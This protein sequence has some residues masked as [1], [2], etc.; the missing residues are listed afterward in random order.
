MENLSLETWILVAGLLLATG[1]L[2]SK[3]S[4]RLDVPALLLFLVVG[5]LAG[6]EGIGGIEFDSAEHARSIG[7]LALVVIL[8]AGGLDT[9]WSS[10]KSVLAPGLALATAGVILTWLSLAAF[11]W[12]VL[13]NYT[14]F[15][16]GTGGIGWPEALLLA[17]IVS[18]T[19]AAAVFSVFRTSPVQPNARL[20]SLLELESGS[21][22]PMAVLITT[23]MLGIMTG[24]EASAEHI[25]L[26]LISQLTLGTLIGL[27]LGFAGAWLVRHVRLS[28]PGLY[29]V[30]VLA[31]GL[32]TFGLADLVNGNGFLA[33]YIA[34]VV[35]GNNMRSSRRLPVMT[36]H[37][38]LSWVCQITMF[39]TLGLLAFPSQLAPVAPVSIV[40]ALFLMFVARPLGVFLCLLPF[41]FKRNEMAYTSWVG[42]RGS[43]PV[44]LATFPTAYGVPGGE[45]IFN[46]VFFI[47]L[48]SMLLQGLTLVR[49]A[50]WLNVIETK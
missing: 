28:A 17:A 32:C 27:M 11:S 25:A 33:V 20:R 19:D 1:V 14:E 9:R 46:V 12:F 5:M 22:D 44:V 24:Q 39:I 50:R 41:K 16:V 2:S 35:L 23:T 42:L 40:I 18:S 34:G 4:E 48:T 26:N 29:P 36:F 6:S 47:V 31:V 10:V 30:L 13:A 15:E 7:T 45:A 37:D 21:N 8:F 38:G 49:S 43:V 3:L